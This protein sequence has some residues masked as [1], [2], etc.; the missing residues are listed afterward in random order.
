MDEMKSW[1]RFEYAKFTTMDIGTNNFCS[2]ELT[3]W[4]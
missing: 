4:K 2:W 1:M 3:S